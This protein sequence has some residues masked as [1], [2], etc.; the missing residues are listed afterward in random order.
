MKR[1]LLLLFLAA[2]S[3]GPT[4][5]PVGSGSN[6]YWSTRW[7]YSYVQPGYSV[8]LDSIQGQLAI[9]LDQAPRDSVL[10]APNRDIIAYFWADSVGQDTVRIPELVWPANGILQARYIQDPDGTIHLVNPQPATT[11]LSHPAAI[12]RQMGDTLMFALSVASQ[13]GDTT[14]S[15]GIFFLRSK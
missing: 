4:I 9:V 6:V 1:L 8:G 11:F 7:T 14:V 13:T 15:L 5:P 3:R 12:L 10:V 2:C